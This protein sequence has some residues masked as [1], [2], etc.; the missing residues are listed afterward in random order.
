MLAETIEALRQLPQDS[1]D[2]FRSDDRNVDAALR[3]LQV[4]IQILIDVGSHLVAQL[5]LGAPETSR[6]LLNRLESAGRLPPGSAQRFGKTFA[7]RNRIVHLYDRVDDEFVYEIITHNLCDLE[8]L[9]RH[10]I[11]AFAS[12]DVTSP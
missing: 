1:L 5:G 7:F 4:G 6:D 8:E 10:Y 11:D 12:L 2:A 3:R 9:A